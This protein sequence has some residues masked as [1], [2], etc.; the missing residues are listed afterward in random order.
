LKENVI[1]RTYRTHK[2]DLKKQK[3]LVGEIE[4]KR[5]IG[6]TKHRWFLKNRV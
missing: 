5:K 1:V 6:R 2:G 3:F 4:G